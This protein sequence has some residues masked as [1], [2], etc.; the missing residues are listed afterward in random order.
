M[1]EKK[2]KK[3]Q[4]KKSKRQQKEKPNWQPLSMMSTIAQLLM[5]TL[6]LLRGY[7]KISNRRANQS[8][9]LSYFT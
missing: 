5:V 6:R 4:G 1:S 7:K 8:S 9:Q 3:K 2:K